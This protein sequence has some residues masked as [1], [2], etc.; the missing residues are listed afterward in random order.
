MDE[1]ADVSRRALLRGVAGATAA[2]TAAGTAAAQ[3]GEGGEG[4]GSQRPVFPSYV[5][6]ARDQ[7]YED[8]R[9]ESEVTISVGA[10]SE[11]LS[12]APTFVWIDEGTEVTWEWTGEGGGHNVVAQSGADFRSGDPVSQAGTTFSHTFEA[13]GMVTYYCNPHE[14]LGMKGAIAVGGGVE[15]ESVGGGSAGPQLPDVAKSV[16]VAAGF[17]MAA[18]LALAYFFIKYGGRGGD[19]DTA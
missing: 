19:A 12:F 3:E 4:G 17:A 11:G 16:G 6:D 10:G 8:L 13:S 7:G 2:S 1:S 14:A 15:T 18:T 9:G 5:D